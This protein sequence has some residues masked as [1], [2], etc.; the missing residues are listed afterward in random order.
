MEATQNDTNVRKYDCTIIVE[1]AA[2]KQRLCF[3]GMLDGDWQA[4]GWGT[5]WWFH[6]V[7][8]RSPCNTIEYRILPFEGVHKTLL[9][10]YCRRLPITTLSL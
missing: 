9:F 5:V 4:G 1:D 6:P 3:C 10:W 2:A 7:K 8:E